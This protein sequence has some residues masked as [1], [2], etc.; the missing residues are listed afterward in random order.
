MIYV[1]DT[2]V[3][4]Q[5]LK[6]DITVTDRFDAAVFAGYR[7]IVPRAVD[8]EI[9]RGLALSK[10]TRKALIYNDMTSPMPTGQCE[11]VDMGEQIWR[12]AKEIYVHLYQKGFT[13]G[14]IDILIGA[15]CLQHN[16]TLV[17]SNTKD[18]VNI[19]GL[20]IINWKE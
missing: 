4:I 17:T 19:D 15:Y 12:L 14:E 3:I 8:Y 1:L 7:L 11:I 2:N 6:K 5:Y 9:R 18:F 10:A 13:V 16:Y 20:K